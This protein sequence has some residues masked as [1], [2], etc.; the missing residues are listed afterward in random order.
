MLLLSPGKVKQLSLLARMP[1]L[2]LPFTLLLLATIAVA[3]SVT[4]CRLWLVYHL[5]ALLALS[6]L[7]EL[8]SVPAPLAVGAGVA[9]KVPR[10]TAHS[11]G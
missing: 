2:Q 11:K 3:A 10:Q 7:E 6:A 4:R 8:M 5:Q 9:R 1:L